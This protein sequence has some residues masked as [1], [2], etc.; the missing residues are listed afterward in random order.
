MELY[1][2]VVVGAGPYGLS[3]AAHLRGRGLR[4]AVFGRTME[5]WRKHMPKGMLLRSHWWATNLS[6]P[7]REFGFERFCTESKRD[8]R[9]PV[10]IDTFIEYGQ[11]FQQR[12]VPEIDET[13]VASIERNGE[14]FLLTLADGREVRSRAVVMA[15]GL[16]YYANRPEPYDK[17]PAGLVSHTSDHGDFG[18]FEGR[19]VVVIGGAQSAIESA[20]LLVEAG[21]TVDVV[22]RRPIMWLAPERQRSALERLRAPDA[23]I[24]P[25]WQNWGLDRFPFFFYRFSQKKKDRYNTYYMAGATHWLRSRVIGKATLHEGQTVTNVEAVDGQAAV[26]ISDGATARA[27]HILLGTGYRVNL[28]RLA[29][30]HPSLRAEIQSERGIPE[31]SH[32]FESSVPGLYFVGITSLRGFGPLYRFVAGCGAAARR[33]AGAV[34]RAQARRPEHKAARPARVPEPVGERLGS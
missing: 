15:I 23:M 29:M 14:G 30:L 3:T 26:T 8:K 9:Y 5:M 33:V 18:R 31:L 24:A 28:D 16:R 25:G 19:H 17:V 10:P 2:A 6:D 13:Y 7:R 22:S 4:V 20:A 1:D 21:A 32:W 27:D 34:A 11:W 12:A